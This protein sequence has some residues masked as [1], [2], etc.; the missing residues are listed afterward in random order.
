[1]I[2]VNLR[3]HKNLHKALG[4]EAVRNKRSLNAEMAHGGLSNVNTHP[5]SSCGTHPHVAVV[6][7]CSPKTLSVP[8]AGKRYLGIGRNASYRTA[9][10]GDIPT[11]RVGGLLRV[12][13]IQMERKLAGEGGS[14]VPSAA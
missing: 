1:M 6:R 11:I 13:V 2:Q 8:V 9:E 3:V 5:R 10:R 14:N 7:R 12:P 4:R